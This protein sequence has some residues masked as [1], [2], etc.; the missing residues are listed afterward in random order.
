MSRVS[1][2]RENGRPGNAC[3]GLAPLR[4]AGDPLGRRSSLTFCHRGSSLLRLDHARFMRPGAS[5]AKID[6]TFLHA[7]SLM[8][9]Y[10][11]SVSAQGRIVSSAVYSPCDQIVSSLVV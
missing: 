6:T 9:D 11:V 7:T 3:S 10:P 4:S 2:G 5:S 8:I 1:M